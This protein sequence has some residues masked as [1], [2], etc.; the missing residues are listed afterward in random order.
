MFSFINFATVIV[1]LVTMFDDSTQLVT[2]PRS[3]PDPIA[4]LCRALVV[5]KRE[6]YHIRE[7]FKLSSD[8]HTE[9][10]YWY[11]RSQYIEALNA[12]HHIN[13][14]VSCYTDYAS[15]MRQRTPCKLDYDTH[16]VFDIVAPCNDEEDDVVVK[17][18]ILLPPE[19]DGTV[20]E[21]RIFDLD[22]RDEYGE[23]PDPKTIEGLYR[24]YKD[25]DMYWTCADEKVIEPAD[26]VHY[27]RQRAL[28][29]YLTDSGHAGLLMEDD[30]EPLEEPLKRTTDWLASKDESRFEELYTAYAA[31]LYAAQTKRC[32]NLSRAKS[33]VQDWV[34][35]DCPPLY[36]CTTNQKNVSING[37]GITLPVFSNVLVDTYA[38]KFQL[39]DTLTDKEIDALLKHLNP[40]G[41]VAESL[42]FAK[43]ANELGQDGLWK[44]REEVKDICKAINDLL[45]EPVTRDAI[46]KAQTEHQRDAMPMMDCGWL[47]WFPLEGTEFAE[48]FNTVRSTG[49]GPYFL[50][51]DMPIIDQS[52]NVQSYG[53]DVVRDLVSKRLGI[54]IYYVR[55]LD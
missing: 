37:F 20:R 8:G 17:R 50:D 30:F 51:I 39:D 24:G 54:D 29:Q 55:H 28:A 6:R 16:R 1:F 49:N 23:L 36:R 21:V 14:N 2:V 15:G 25:R 9:K 19:N 10:V 5:L 38:C 33:F 18:S 22:E 13:E 34:N 43:K 53:G 26:A 47:N 3:S 48:K 46:L 45:N 11:G 7:V 4:E 32:T 52:V 41:A 31:G 40:K 27:V 44:L 12:P 42:N 35:H